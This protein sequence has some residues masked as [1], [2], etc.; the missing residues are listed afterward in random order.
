MVQCADSSQLSPQHQAAAY[1]SIRKLIWRKASQSYLAEGGDWTSD[2]QQA[3]AFADFCAAHEAA[4]QFPADTV[5]I[6][7]SFDPHEPS[8]YDFTTALP[9][10]SSASHPSQ[11]KG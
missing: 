10:I 1:A 4:T 11:D 5:E 6:Y 8:Q 2:I 3:R 7:Y 9:L